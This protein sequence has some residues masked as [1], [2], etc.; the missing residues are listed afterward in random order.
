MKRI[1]TLIL[2]AAMLAT[3][4]AFTAFADNDPSEAAQAVI[5]MIF[6]LDENSTP[7]QLR[8]AVDAYEALSDEDKAAVWNYSAIEEFE[9]Q[10]VEA[11][12]KAIDDLGEYYEIDYYNKGKDIRDALAKYEVLSEGSKAKVTNYDKLAE[13]KAKIDGLLEWNDDKEVKLLNSALNGFSKYTLDSVRDLAEKKPV[14]IYYYFEEVDMIERGDSTTGYY[15][16]EDLELV[17]A[18]KYAKLDFDIK[19][20]DVDVINGW[21]A[22]F[23]TTI[24]GELWAG[25]DFVNGMFFQGKSGQ[26]HC[27]ISNF[28]AAEPFEIDFGVWH[29]MTITYDKDSVIYV[30]DGVEVLNTTSE[31]LYDYFIIYPWLCNFEM[32]NV[33][34]TYGSGKTTLSPFRTYVANPANTGWVRGTNDPDATMLDLVQESLDEARSKYNHLSD[35]EKERVIGIEEL[36]RVQALIDIARDGKNEITVFDGSA[37][38][39]YAAAGATVTLT[40]A[41]APEGMQFDKWEII[42]GEFEIADVNAAYTTFVMPDSPVEL[43]AVYKEKPQFTP[44]DTNGDGKINNRDVILTMKAVLAVSSGAELPTGLVFDAADM[45]GDGKLN[46]R[47]VIAVMKAVLAEAS[48]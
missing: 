9:A 2:C 13:A 27:G 18:Y 43:K 36:D 37:D 3:S 34:L 8:A 35:D 7:D 45:N 16:P 14:G 44:A 33:N 20:T 1:L 40:A 23:R 10:Y 48:K 31:G 39:E 4:F 38:A 15:H 19:F 42:S 17:V 46:N 6:A 11:L 32:T 22:L 21:P 28:N 41:E 25:Y 24:G 29:H 47:D 12:I 5:D 30:F 26:D